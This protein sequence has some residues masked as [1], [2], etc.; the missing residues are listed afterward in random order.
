MRKFVTLSVATLIALSLAG[1]TSSSAD[2]C[3]ALADS[4]GSAVDSVKVT[5][6][7]GVA[8]TATFPTP[9]SVTKAQVKV[10][11]PSEGTK[12][13]PG[14]AYTF[15]VALYNGKTGESLGASSFNGSDAQ[16][17]TLAKTS[18]F[19]F[20]NSVIQCAR[21]G[22]R[23]VGVVPN[24]E[25]VSA[26]GQSLTGGDSAMTLVVIADI[27]AASLPRANG[28]PQ[29][30]PD[31]FPSVVLDSKGVPGITVPKTAAPTELKVAVLKK[32]NGATVT[33]TSDV[34]VHYT[35]VLWDGGTVFDSSWKSGNVATFNVGEVV[36]G[37]AKALIGQTVG[38]QIIAIIPPDLAY[39]ATGAGST[40]PP[41][42]TLVFV[43]DIL[44][45]A[46]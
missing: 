22:S 19:S 33:E 44:G 32:G 4:G 24:K 37:F 3:S 29:P 28:E 13:L 2:S 18:Q 45:I 27:T 36:P 30:V 14:S 10:S 25:L 15:E 16:S 1:C 46:K 7:P 31:G 43:V 41:N 17:T 8:P 9:L 38:S 20:M 12:V 42:A 35:G 5:Q 23:I 6:D 34:E 11:T 21:V 26:D 40:V 39:G